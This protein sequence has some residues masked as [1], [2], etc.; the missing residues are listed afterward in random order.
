MCVCVQCTL[1]MARV[2]IVNVSTKPITNRKPHKTN[3][4]DQPLAK[5]VMRSTHHQRGIGCWLA[6]DVDAD[7]HCQPLPCVLAMTLIL[8]NHQ[9]ATISNSALSADVVMLARAHT[10]LIIIRDPSHCTF[11]HATTRS[12]VC[13]CPY[14]YFIVFMCTSTH[15][16][17]MYEDNNA[18]PMLE[19][20]Q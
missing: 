15:V 5:R 10:Q 4:R 6:A 18:V 11:T 9:P 17:A 8:Y 16:Y 14:T 12:C 13:V 19:R 1:L 2:C 20:S 3:S 7:A